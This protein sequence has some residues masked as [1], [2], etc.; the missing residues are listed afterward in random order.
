MGRSE[1]CHFIGVVGKECRSVSILYI[2]PV[3]VG[4]RT[5]ERILEINLSSRAVRRVLRRNEE[6]GASL[7]LCKDSLLD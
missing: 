1:G 5:E 2:P 7:Q 6:I 4:S 3:F